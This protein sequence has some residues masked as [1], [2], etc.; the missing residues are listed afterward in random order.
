MQKKMVFHFRRN[1]TVISPT[2][3]WNNVFEIVNS[4]KLLGL[5]INDDFIWNTKMDYIFKKA[6]KRLYFLKVLKSYHAPKK[7][8]KAFYT[9]V[10][11]S[12]L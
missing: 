2:E 8:L 10:V 5:W 4:Y 9:S 1:K 6:A 11:R 3:I 12:T 7:D